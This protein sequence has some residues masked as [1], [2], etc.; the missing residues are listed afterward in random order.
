M[1][2]NVLASLAAAGLLVAPIAAQ[3]NTRAGDSRVSLAALKGVERAASQI[4]PARNQGDGDDDRGIPIWLLV[5][6]FGAA[7]GGIIAAVELTQSTKS[8]GT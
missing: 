6:L 7:G 8:P 5:L 2:R 4:G 3:A 1:L